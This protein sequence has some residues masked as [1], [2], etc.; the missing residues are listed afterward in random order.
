MKWIVSLTGEGYYWWICNTPF[1]EVTVSYNE[2]FERGR[3]VCADWY[4]FDL[5]DS[6]VEIGRFETEE[7]G[8]QAA[9]QYFAKLAKRMAR[10]AK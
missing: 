8:K 9:G 1:G 7:E 5:S 3:R 10:Y 2:H 4:P 6:A